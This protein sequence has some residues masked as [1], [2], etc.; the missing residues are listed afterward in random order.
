MT[1][2]HP[3]EKTEFLGVAFNYCPNEDA[4]LLVV[5]NGQYQTGLWA[6]HDVI[7]SDWRRLECPVCGYTLTQY[8]PPKIVDWTD[9]QAPEAFP[10]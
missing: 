9:K 2:K 3:I 5:E 1:K 10:F 8:D 4:V 6:D 7:L